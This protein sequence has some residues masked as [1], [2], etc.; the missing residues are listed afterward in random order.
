MDRILHQKVHVG[1]SACMFGAK[2]RYNGKGWD[3]VSHIGREKGDFIWHPVC[4]EVLAGLGVPRSAI[5]VAGVSGKEVW[6]GNSSVLTRG[7]MNISQHMMAGA[8][9]GMEALEASQV[10][11]FIYMEGSPSCGVYR[12]SLKNKRIGKPPGVFG[13]KLLEKQWFLIPAQDLQSPVR[14]WDWR[15]RLHAFVWLKHMDIEDVATLFEVWHTLKFLC[16]EID[17]KQARDLGSKLA[18]FSKK[19]PVEDLQNVKWAILNILRSPSTVSKI[20][21][22]LWKHYVY[23]RKELDIKVDQIKKPTDVRGMHKIAEELLLLERIAWKSG[24]FFASSPILYRGN[25]VAG[26]KK[27][28]SKA[29]VDVPEESPEESPEDL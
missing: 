26:N 15:R 24:T 23:L 4:P 13:A 7:G 21:N 18:H 6:D 20:A 1:I 27:V 28:V 3:M 17:E 22:R 16:Q 5:R 12:T 11:A 9:R 8:M 10:E 2:V 25:R 19:T 29:K 14:W